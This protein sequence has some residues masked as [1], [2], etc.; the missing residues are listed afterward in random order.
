MV[1]RRAAALEDADAD[2][3]E[4]NHDRQSETHTDLIA[5]ADRC[6]ATKFHP[7]SPPH[8]SLSLASHLP[9]I[10]AINLRF[11]ADNLTIT[12]VASFSAAQTHTC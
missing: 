9:S 12:T 4:Y 7:P 11:A 3:L 2:A 5:L 10:T 6:A 1:W 8:S